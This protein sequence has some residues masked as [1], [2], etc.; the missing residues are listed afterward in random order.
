MRRASLPPSMLLGIV[1][2]TAGPVGAGTGRRRQARGGPPAAGERREEVH[3]RG[4][5]VAVPGGRG[6]GPGAPRTP[7]PPDRVRRTPRPLMRRPLHDCRSGRRTPASAEAKAMADAKIAG[8]EAC[9]RRTGAD[10][11]QSVRARAKSTRPRR[12]RP[13]EAAGQSRGPAEERR[14]LLPR[15]GA[16]GDA[17]GAR[18]RRRTTSS[19][20]RPNGTAWKR[21]P[22]P[23]KSPPTGCASRLNC[24]GRCATLT[25]YFASIPG[26]RRR[27]A[28]SVWRLAAPSKRWWSMSYPGST[29]PAIAVLVVLTSVAA[30]VR[31]D[32]QA[33]PAGTPATA[34]P[35][36]RRGRRA[37]VRRHAEGAA[38]SVLR[39]L[40]QRSAQDREP[41][42]RKTG[43]R[44]ASATTPS[45]GRKSSA[46][47]AP[48]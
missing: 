37:S 21:A 38:R 22:R 8:E 19:R 24:R 47:C 12:R 17:E 32:G 34:P 28:V 27:P 10:K 30:V 42:A 6:S 33:T 9:P 11:A 41:V 31:V 1:W 16:R 25:Y 13:E 3:E 14:R 18:E 23:R 45:C 5:G 7:R 46:S 4:S 26:A 2:L 48:A 40:P 44:D 43:P 35:P 15:P 36:L 20:C 29:A 39:H